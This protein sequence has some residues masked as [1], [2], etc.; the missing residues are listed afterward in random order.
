MER[1][2]HRDGGHLACDVDRRDPARW[3]LFAHGF[4]SDRRGAK[5]T[6]VREAAGRAGASFVALDFR[7]HG[8]SS[9]EIAA[10]TPSRMLEDLDVVVEALV[11]RDATL[12]V[13]GSSLGGLA[14]AWWSAT[15]ERK[16]AANVL[17]APAFGF[18]DRFL[19]EIGPERAAAWAREGVLRYRNE[20]LDVPLRHALVEDARRLSTTASRRRTRRTR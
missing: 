19:A 6:A 12:C 17:V 8:E 14:A 15:R 5:A 4:G 7:G 9:G 16:P 18:L 2:P 13:V 3:W 11:P 20:W 10:L 1:L